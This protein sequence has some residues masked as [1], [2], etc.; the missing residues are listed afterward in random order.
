MSLQQ[1]F[2]RVG[3]LKNLAVLGGI[4]LL[5]VPAQ[6]QKTL[7]FMMDFW[8]QR[9]QT[10]TIINLKVKQSTEITYL[11]GGGVPA[12][13]PVDAY[14][15]EKLGWWYAIPNFRADDYA[16]GRIRPTTTYMR[17]W[18]QWDLDKYVP[19]GDTVF[20]PDTLKTFTY[21]NMVTGQNVTVT[22]PATTPKFFVFPDSARYKAPKLYTAQGN[23]EAPLLNMRTETK[24]GLL[25]GNIDRCVDSIPGDT[26]WI[27]FGAINSKPDQQPAVGTLR[28]TGYNPYST[29]AA[30]VWLRNP[31]PGSEQP[32]VE[33]NGQNVPLYPSATNPDWLVADLRYIAPLG[34]PS[35]TIRFK[36][37]A[38]SSIYFDSAGVEQGVVKPFV[39]PALTGGNYYFVPPEAGGD[40]V[41]A[42]GTPP[43]PKY[44]I[45]VQNPWKP[46][47]PRLL[48]ESDKG[49]HVMRPTQSCG[50]FRYPVYSTPTRVLIGHSFEDSSYGSAGVQFRTRSNWIDIPAASIVKN[51][52]YIQTRDGSGNRIPATLTAAPDLKDCS[53][54]TLRLV[55]QAYDFKGRGETGG[56]PAFQVG[57]ATDLEGKASSG[58]VKKMV[59]S[60]LVGPG[61][62]PVYTGRD[63]GYQIG[64]I[65]GIGKGIAG[66]P[67]GKSTPSN[68]FDTAALAA[69][70]PGIAIGRSCLELPLAKGPADSGYYKYDNQSFFPLDTISDRRGFSPLVGG[71]DKA[72]HNFL[73]C[74]HGHAAFEYTPGLKFEFRGDDDVWV[75]VNNKLAVDLGGT[76]AP[77]S[78][79]INLDKMKLRE[80]GVY[81]FDI[82]YCERQTNGSSILIRTTMDLQPTWRYRAKVASS[83]GAIDIVIEGEKK[84]NYVPNCASLRSGQADQWV[85]TDGRMVVIGPDG[86]DLRETY[87]SDVSLYGGNLTYSGGAIKIDTNKLKQEMELK[88]PGVYTIRVESRLGDSLHSISFTKTYGAVVVVGK[89]LDTDGDGVADSMRISAPRPILADDPSYHLAWFDAAGRKDSVLPTVAQV[90]KISDSSAM[91]PLSGKAWGQRTRIP[92]GAK[93]DTMN[94]ILTHPDGLVKAIVN[95]IKLVDGI[96]PVADSAFLKYSEPGSGQDD[97]LF[98]WASEPVSKSTTTSPAL[99]GWAVLGSRALPRLVA[100]EAVPVGDGSVLAF[101]FPPALDPVAVGDSVRLGGWAADALRN[102]PGELSKWVPIKSNSVANGWMLDKNGDGAPDSVGIISKGDLSKTDSVR[103][104]W[105]TATGL[106]TVVSVATPGGV[107]SG[108]A[109]PPGIL[110]GATFCANCRIETF[111]AGKA[112][113]FPLADSVPAIATK[114]S[115]RYGTTVDTLVVTVSESVVKGAAI[116]EGLAGQKSAGD[117]PFGKGALVV[118]TGADSSVAKVLRIV[119]APGVVTGDSA[120]LRGWAKD[121]F[122][123][124][125]GEVSPFVKIDFGP[126]PIRTVVW[127]R[128]GDGTVDSVAYRLTRGASGVGQPD[129][130]GLVWSGGAAAPGAL[131]RD[132]A[133]WTGSVSGAKPLTT[134]IGPDDAGWLV[135]GADKDSYRSKVEDSVA[136]VAWNA[137]L[138]YGFEDGAPD[139]IVVVGSEDLAVGS[140][141][142]LMLGTDSA[143][144]SPTMLTSAQALNQNA[145][146]GNQLT[147]VVPAGSIAGDA[148][149]VRFGPGIG[150]KKVSVG[151]SSR[152]VRLVV[153]PSGRAYLFDSDG[154]GTADLMKIAVKGSLGAA[155]T[156]KLSWSDA[157]GKSVSKDWP[158]V[159]SGAAFEV[160]PSS[161]KWFA[162]GATSCPGTCMVSFSDVNGTTLATWNLV[163]SVAPMLLGGSYRFGGDVDTLTVDFSEPLQV[164]NAKAPWLEWGGVALGGAV[165]HAE[166]KLSGASATFLLAGADRAGKGWDSLRMAAGTRSGAV[167]D[168]Q[169]TKVGAT[170]PW[171]PVIYGLPPMQA[172]ILDPRGEGR[173]TDVEIR[174]VREVPAAAISGVGSILLD[175][176][177]AAGTGTEERSVPVSSL[178]YADGIW[179]GALAEPFAVAAT[180]PVDGCRARAVRGTESR[181]MELVDG[182][183]PVLVR[184]RYRFSLPVVAADTMIADLSEPWTAGPSGDAS[185]AIVLVGTSANSR[186]FQPMLNWTLSADKRQ[187]TMVVDTSWE[188]ILKKNDSARLIEAGRVVDAAGNQVGAASRWVRIEF[189]LRP[190]QLDIAPYPKAVMANTSKDGLAWSEPGPGVPAIELLVRDPFS[191]DT[192]W[193]RTETVHSGD[194][195]AGAPPVNPVHHMLGIK[196]RLNRP[197]EGTLIIYDNL[198]VA[199][200][201]ID[202]GQL[203]RIWR[204]NTAEKDQLRDVWIAWNGTDESGKFAAS[205]VYLFR[206]VVKFEDEGRLVFRNLVWKLGWHRDPS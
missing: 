30:L 75:F 194:L 74:L 181:G 105:K 159:P 68:W 67:Y 66:G 127:D 143:S 185:S 138:V 25:P 161:D 46:G 153:T 11:A 89:V 52:V 36:K 184:S 187:L 192:T 93:I 108:V 100:G 135:F 145:A 3:R 80:G 183:P 190:V 206:A 85:Q 106:D 103:V 122:G 121:A 120:R 78:A 48:W 110:G 197:L 6:A 199:V 136:P 27:R 44:Y 180:A 31:W 188:T 178:A 7:M 119:V 59:Q 193:R 113:K 14:E 57:G 189:G 151:A 132:G 13:V 4:L 191:G 147:M 152:W 33:F 43:T 65:N 99:A 137:K 82:F 76:H 202:L 51:N 83:G 26:I 107:G 45:Y 22:L 41:M 148:G 200:R 55:M 21:Q 128:D 16:Y 205:G 134:A 123:N 40:L 166:A 176:T 196:I 29:R 91:A 73:F 56:N 97:T 114:A 157:T 95:P 64:G 28:C 115:Y 9:D 58:L 186:P 204:E 60:D 112:S 140:G 54:D 87:L 160:H 96:A 117:P 42:P 69:A 77:E 98:V 124:V 149:W 172:K 34:T 158:M 168:K 170:S 17:G 154:D 130:F 142:W 118:G 165:N 1:F 175:W 162:K 49:Y 12:M 167:L 20:L 39:L 70:V 38:S 182:I 174:L 23:S 24:S 101:A 50:W 195:S 125:P 2:S 171:A 164:A 133:S 32:V 109:L 35:P 179:Q 62:L 201:Q 150:D 155:V 104:Y 15:T 94:A 102:A 37:S 173:G 81:P 177:N 63:S 141:A 156:A 144:G 18:Y 126:Q 79:S 8:G 131:V 163:D 146:S 84:S 116:G 203:G 129:G 19:A 86:S 5:S 10:D 198:G 169:G 53:T 72:P 92:S 71:L 139:T 47:S 61:Y 111:E 88:W 90:R